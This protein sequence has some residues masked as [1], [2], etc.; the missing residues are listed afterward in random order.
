MS[1]EESF[2]RALPRDRGPV[3]VGDIVYIPLEADGY[4]T[5]GKNLQALYAHRT[6][7]SLLLTNE[8]Q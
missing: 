8:L 2:F 3:H 1:D 7:L 5:D 4:E 6:L